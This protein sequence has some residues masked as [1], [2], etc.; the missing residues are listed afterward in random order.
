MPF[1]Y[2]D[3]DCGVVS[4]APVTGARSAARSRRRTIRMRAVIDIADEAALCS[5]V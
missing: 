1:G 4:W 5:H 2:R 3:Y